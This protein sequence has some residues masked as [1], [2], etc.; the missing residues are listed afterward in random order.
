[1]AIEITRKYPG[2][3][4]KDRILEWYL[5]YNFYGNAAYGIEAAARVYYDK[6]VA[7]L[8]LTRSRCWRPSRNTPV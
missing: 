5:N 6:T 2:K 1:M 7:D 8:T 4:G 3:A